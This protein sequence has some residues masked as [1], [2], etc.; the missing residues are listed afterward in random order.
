MYLYF[1]LSALKGSDVEGI[2]RGDT[3]LTKRAEAPMHSCTW[4]TLCITA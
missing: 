3:Y 4:Y 1:A 2:E